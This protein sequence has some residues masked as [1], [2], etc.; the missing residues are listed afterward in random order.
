MCDLHNSTVPVGSSHYTGVAVDF[1]LSSEAH[2]HSKRL[3]HML[4]HR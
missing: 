3:S 2:A 4:Y 1:G